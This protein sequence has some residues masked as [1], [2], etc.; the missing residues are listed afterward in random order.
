MASEQDRHVRECSPNG[1]RGNGR[2]P[3]ATTRP[4]GA[5]HRISSGGNFG[6]V[7]RRGACSRGPS[8]LGVSA[9]LLSSVIA[10][11]TGI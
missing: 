4:E 9:R 3:D 10:F 7:L 5:I 8:S 2:R 6:G 1:C 11:G